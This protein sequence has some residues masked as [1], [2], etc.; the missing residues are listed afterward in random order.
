MSL[1]QT[2]RLYL[3][4]GNFRRTA[5]FREGRQP[6]SPPVPDG[7]DFHWI[8]E[9]QWRRN[10]PAVKCPDSVA[11]ERFGNG[12]RCL[13]AT[14]SQGDTIHEMWIVP[15]GS[16]TEWINA[17]VEVPDGYAL[18]AGGWTHPDWRRRYL[19]VCAG[20]LGAVEACRMGRPGLYVG[21]EEHEILPRAER[22]AKS[23]FYPMEPDR[24]MVHHRL[25]G[26]SWHRDEPPPADMVR[27]CAE[28]VRRNSHHFFD[29]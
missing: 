24:V 13:I 25:L 4:R 7:V 27:N 6:P 26:Y 15:S 3:Y 9:A 28:A 21:I 18:F 10:K 14:D 17:V 16:W 29:A 23:G 2:R 11:A 19:M 8:T 1:I 5:W 20:A 12:G 22:N